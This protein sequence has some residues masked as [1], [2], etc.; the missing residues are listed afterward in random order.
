MK[1]FIYL[2]LF[3]FISYNSYG[4]STPDSIIAKSDSL[5]KY[6]S[7]NVAEEFLLEQISESNSLK[8]QFL[9]FAQLCYLSKS[10]SKVEKSIKYAHK[11]DSKPF[12]GF[13]HLESYGDVLYNLSVAKFRLGE[14][15]STFYY[16]KKAL[17][18]RRQH[19]PANHKKIVQNLIA[20]G[21][22]NSNIGQVELS[23][24]YQ[25]QALAIA[26]KIKPLDYNSLVSTYFSLGSAYQ[27]SNL[28]FK[29]RENY[30]NALGFYQDSLATN[31]NYKAHIYNAIGVILESQKDY[32]SAQEHY[33]E[34][35]VLF[36]KTNDIFTVATAYSNLANNYTN[37]GKYT[38]AK[39]IHNKVI[40]L[41][42]GGNYENELP[43]KYLN[44]GATYMEC[45]QY[46]SALFVLDKAYT[47][48]LKVSKSN[49]ELSTIILNHYGATYM[50]LN[51]F[52]KAESSL[53][54]SIKIA[55]NLFG[56]K[57][58]DLAES[59][60]LLAKNYYSQN[61]H[62][63]VIELLT[64]A[65]DA[66][67]LTKSSKLDFTEEIISR[68][69]L[70]DIYLLKEN[71]LWLEYQ[72]NKNI[73]FLS[74]LYKETIN[75]SLLSEVIMDF[76]EHENAK[77]NIF[78]AVNENLYL[79]I[80]AAKELYNI[81]GDTQYIQQALTFFEVEKSFLLKQEYKDL[82]AKNSNQISDS[83]L[84][85]EDRLKREISK[86]QN[87]LFT[88]NDTD[89]DY[90]INL[91]TTIFELKR[92]LSKLLSDLEQ[93]NP[94]YYAQKYQKLNYD[95]DTIRAELD[96]AELFIEYF[97]YQ[98][99]V[100]S[101][102]ISHNSTTFEQTIISD[103]NTKITAYNNAILNSDI[104]SYSELAQTF[105]KKIVAIHPIN[106]SISQLTIVPSKSISFLSFDSFITEKPTDLSFN[107][108]S[109]LIKNKT[110]SYKNSLQKTHSNTLK[111]EELYIG[112]SPDFSNNTL[113]N[114]KGANDEVE[115]ISKQFNGVILNANTGL[116]KGLLTKI[117]NYK[118][119]HF[120]THAHL[121]TQNSSYS[122]LLLNSDTLDFQSKLH[123]FEIQNTKLNT[124]LIVLSACNT[125]VGELK[126]G[127]GLASLARS[128]N[129][130]G[131]HSVVVGLW[132]LPDR[133]TSIIITD[134][135]REL[136]TNNKAIALRNA[137][138]NYLNNSD[139]HTANPLYWAGLILIGEKVAIDLNLPVD[140][141]VFYLIALSV[142]LISVLL[143]RKKLR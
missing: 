48:N 76:Y 53:K 107:K 65:E 60:F 50:E 57:D 88:E 20:L 106:D 73:S 82:V 21:I 143:I 49:N 19:L 9:F 42:E 121:N 125:G 2:L 11:A 103:L 35:I 28:L 72:K 29:A 85:R 1:R 24:G 81:T 3:I 10:N 138:I 141:N 79:G 126:K 127:E 75:S 74:S 86:N 33:K 109:Y 111:P 101:I 97:Q 44:L 27:S 71:T 87:L 54:E 117:S 77:L 32:K 15:D 61:K 25:E 67:I 18:T 134:F 91:S 135:F 13:R 52:D 46:D 6:E 68:T 116:K 123:A 89:S 95:L 113:R 30:D 96:P 124:E 59:Y 38:K 92:A 98:D 99:E 139:E 108:L 128:F 64:K 110:I 142:L 40:S 140:R 112:I 8:N 56:L 133:S 105:Y 5:L 129:Y 22:F 55:Q 102:S 119:I 4:K 93:N 78:N 136:T 70:L 63:S 37:L 94:I 131:A 17:K 16:A 41:F 132:S 14:I 137:K 7:F 31:K 90:S 115:L 80:K 130:A 69:L 39:K 100:F 66:L 34:A 122:S 104:V 84:L 12:S 43:W 26:L 23:I 58:I 114:L 83:L 62:S 51:A 118:I 36:N 45:L 120:A 47:L